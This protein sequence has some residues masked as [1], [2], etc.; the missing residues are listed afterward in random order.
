MVSTS[1][2]SILS[3]V[4]IS[5]LNK[6]I[7]RGIQTSS[8]EVRYYLDIILPIDKIDGVNTVCEIRVGVDIE[9]K[10]VDIYNIYFNVSIG[11]SKFD[12]KEDI[13]YK[14]LGVVRVLK[15]TTWCYPNNQTEEYKNAVSHWLTLKLSKIQKL[16][17]KLR[18]SP[19]RDCLTIN[20]DED[21]NLW[22][23]KKKYCKEIEK[24]SNAS[25]DTRVES[26]YKECCVCA[27]ETTNKTT[28][29]HPICIVCLSR[30]NKQ[31]CPICR[32]TIYPDDDEGSSESDDGSEEDYDEDEERIDE[33]RIDE[34]EDD[35]ANFNADLQ[36]SIE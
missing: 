8:G 29:N 35:I 15:K 4:I 12:Q 28:C 26:S 1:M 25:T 20:Y 17:T 14:Y 27:E 24:S 7:Y 10:K 36:V 31:K 13:F 6:R 19:Q 33:E 21:H 22:E 18:V 30:L 2:S 23:A 16:I 3:S 9:S 34:H 32:G 5:K 11:T